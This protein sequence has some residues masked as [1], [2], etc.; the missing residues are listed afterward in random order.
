MTAP[1]L[2]AL[3]GQVPK[4]VGSR[5]L[6]REDL[7]AKGRVPSN[8]LC[9]HELVFAK[10]SWAVSRCVSAFYDPFERDAND[11]RGARQE[12]TSGRAG[13]ECNDDALDLATSLDRLLLP[14]VQ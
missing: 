9:F 6:R 11:L 5:C 13:L 7:T 8:N 4:P 3:S 12:A 10:T 1:C 14:L 2:A